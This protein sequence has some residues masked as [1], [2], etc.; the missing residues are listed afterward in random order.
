MYNCRCLLPSVR[1]DFRNIPAD[2]TAK[3]R[4][5]IRWIL[6][7]NNPLKGIT[8]MI[9]LLNRYWKCDEGIFDF[10]SSIMSIY[11]CCSKLYFLRAEMME[12]SPSRMLLHE[13]ECNAKLIVD[14]IY[15][16]PSAQWTSLLWL[17]FVFN[18]ESW[19]GDIIEMQPYV[20]TP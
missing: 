9:F 13:A 6:V 4:Q 12:W 3:L 19:R 2:W 17:T 15:F 10:W 11:S 18:R 1:S 8:S 7:N 20:L 14:L 16:L 5:F